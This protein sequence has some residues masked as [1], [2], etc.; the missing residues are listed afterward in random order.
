[1]RINELE[2]LGR[3][4]EFLD[5]YEEAKRRSEV[6]FKIYLVVLILAFSASLLF[7][8]GPDVEPMIKLD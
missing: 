1:M 3:E 2:E 7:G 6:G 4:Q 8:N 5:N